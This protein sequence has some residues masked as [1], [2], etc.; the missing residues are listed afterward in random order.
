VDITERKRVEHELTTRMQQLDAIRAVSIELTRELDLG[1]LLHLI[2]DRVL[3]LI[4]AGRG[5]IRLWD[6]DNQS[7]VQRTF[8]GSGVSQDSVP[9]RLGEGVAGTVAQRRQGMIVNDFRASPYA[10]PHLVDGTSH[11][12]IMAEP[13]LC[14]DRL[15]GVLSILREA[16]QQPFTEE[17]QQLLPIFATQAA[18][19]IK[20]ARL[21]ESAVQR[22]QQLASLTRLTQSLVSATSVEKVGEEVMTAVQALMPQAVARLWDVKGDD[23]A[24]LEVI[25]SAGLQDTHGGTVRFRRGEGLAGEAV[26]SRRPVVSRDLSQDPRFV[27]KSWAAQEKLV[28][29]ILFPLLIGKKIH[30]I[31]AIFTREPHDFNETEV[32]LFQSLASHAAIAIENVRLQEGAV[33]HGRQLGVLLRSTQSVMSGLDLDRTLQTIVCEAA[34]M[35]GAPVIRLLLLDEDKQ[36]LRF[37]T[38]IGTSQEEEEGLVIRVG[39]SFS[40]QVIATGQPLMV[41]DT[42]EDPRLIHRRHIDKYGLLSYLGLPIGRDATSIGVLVFNSVIPR[43]YSE[44]EVRLLS[45]FAQ[46]AAIAIENARLHE[47]ALRRSTELEA[48]LLSSKTIGS[49]L[50]LG[51]VLEVIVQQASAI[52]AAPIVR[53]FLLDED[54]QFLRCRVAIGFPLK[55]E[56]DLAIPLGASFSGQVAVTGEPL[57]VP[58]TRADSRTYY[59]A[60]ASRYGVV[61][62]LGLPVKFQECLL[63]VLVFNTPAPRQYSADEVAYLSSFAS[64][65]AIAIEN[66]RLH[67]ATVRRGEQ[68]ETIRAVSVEITRELDL[69]ALLHLITER[70]IQVIGG[71][72][73]MIRLWDKAGQWL[74]P[75]AYT[76]SRTHW[77]DSRLHLG[78]GVAGTAAQRRQGMIVNDFR[79]SPYA[80]PLLTEGTT[81]TAVLAEPLLFGDRLVGVLSIEREADQQP[82]AE[83]DRQILA[84]FATQAAIAIENARLH[85]ATVRRGAQLKAL[86]ASLQTVTSGLD[87]REIL[88]RI[89]G[90]AI[91]ISGAPHV[92]VLLVDKTSKVLRVGALRGSGML[93]T[94]ALPVGAGLSGLVAQSGEPLFIVDAQNDPRN[95]ARERDRELGIV[96][97]LGLPIKKGEEVLGVLTFNKISPSQY[98]PEEMILLT[99]FAA[100]AA[101]AIENA[102]LYEEITQHAETLEARVQERTTELAHINLELTAALRQAEAGNQ[103]K[104]DFLINMSHELR[105]PLNSILGFA[106]ILQGQAK[107]GLTD[108]QRRYLDNIY[109]SGQHLLAIVNEI[110]D[111]NTAEAK[112]LALHLTKVNF[113]EVIT[114]AL[115]ATREAVRRKGLSVQALIP[116]DLPVFDADRDRIRQIAICLLSN[117]VKFTPDGGR[118]TVQAGMVTAEAQRS[119][120]AGEPGAPQSPPPRSAVR[121]GAS[122]SAPLQFLEIAVA[123]TGIGIRAEDLPR[124]F[125]MFG[126]LESPLTKRYAGTG[127]GLALAKQLAELHGGTITATSP[128]PGRGSTFTVRLP[129]GGPG[130]EA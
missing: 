65:A 35:S 92:K 26:I 8:T 130:T 103:A 30:G 40:G 45:T 16:G 83:Q 129:V 111:L 69:S 34:A 44:D 109:S 67:E 101:I 56:P 46:Q 112:E 61:S 121:G 10:I 22:A 29:A 84:L 99:S 15:V 106:Q 23:L 76:G 63:G 41:P 4:G 64:Q 125:R 104:S 52:S 5:M 94:D 31:L 25:A 68:L 79:T 50:E 38:G 123:D 90:E 14:D 33:E 108:K 53:L 54:G 71:G 81:H 48:L 13:L 98:T 18:I 96:T 100:Q 80:I 116:P 32:A 62:Y 77:D 105:T 86:L 2:T 128:G 17:D 115:E 12:A 27:N 37:R 47:T 78:E 1:A 19:A 113:T 7:L 119:G 117:A 60:Q 74:V 39:E 42:R 118:I 91:R 66:A 55:D 36:L 89:L 21:H 124:L 110:L 3:E 88:D 107:E 11:T 70:V 24:T 6:E 59:P 126:Q 43:A 82:F 58:D 57:A 93:P 85:E 127:V 114:E 95:L 20:N 87:L 72:H 97:Y 75:R 49:S 120:G 122:P 9:L 102:R 28:S 51:H 73:S